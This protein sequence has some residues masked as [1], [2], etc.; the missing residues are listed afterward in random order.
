VVPEGRRN[1]RDPSRLPEAATRLALQA[2]P[3]EA[4][5]Y[6]P[7]FL[8]GEKVV[9]ITERHVANISGLTRSLAGTYSSSGRFSYKGP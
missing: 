7:L 8:N 5:T 9:G 3:E 2:D 1:A 6:D 4:Q